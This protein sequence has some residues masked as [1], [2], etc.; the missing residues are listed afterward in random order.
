MK[1]LS[2]VFL[3]L[4]AA[5]QGIGRASEP[6]SLTPSTEI[7]EALNREVLVPKG[8]TAKSAKIRAKEIRRITIESIQ[9]QVDSTELADDHSREQ[10]RLLA[11]ALKDPVLINAVVTLVGHASADGD[12]HY[13]ED[14]SRRRSESIRMRLITD[15]GIAGERLSAVGKGESELLPGYPPDASKHRRVEVIREE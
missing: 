5:W 6:P 9:F 12:A 2:L 7:V 15:Y 13:N 10:V 4:M 11:E 14:L 1:A 3:W 8:A